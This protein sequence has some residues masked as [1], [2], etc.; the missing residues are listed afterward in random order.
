[1]LKESASKPPEVV[2]CANDNIALGVAPQARRQGIN[3]PRQMEITGCDGEE[4]TGYGA[5]PIT[6]IVQPAKALA[7]KAAEIIIE[8]LS[9]AT[10]SIDPMLLPCEIRWRESSLGDHGTLK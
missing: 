5:L 7:Q 4:W 9:G 6:T 8:R 10:Q 1:L 2:I 3:I